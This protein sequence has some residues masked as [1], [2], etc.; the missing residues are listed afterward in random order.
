MSF[1][2][3]FDNARS[4]QHFALWTF[5]CDRLI[6]PVKV[7]HARHDPGAALAH[8]RVLA[9][10]HA[11]NLININIRFMIVWICVLYFIVLKCS[12]Y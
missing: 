1:G 12:R 7:A 6:D 11:W 3:A 8:H 5:E 2:D 10:W 9:R 4:T